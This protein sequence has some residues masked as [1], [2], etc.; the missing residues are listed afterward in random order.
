METTTAF[1]LN[2]A[3]QQWRENLRRLPA[4]RCGNLDELESHLRDSIATLQATGLSPEEALLIAARRL[5]SD[6]ALAIEFGKFNTR[7]VWFSRV[8]WALIGI[9]LW[10]FAGVFASTLASGAVFSGLSG[11]SYNF[12]KNGVLLPIILLTLANLVGFAG[13]LGLCWW[14]I[15]R[16]RKILHRRLSGA[17]KS[18]GTLALTFIAA[19]VLVCLVAVLVGVT[20]YLP[21]YYT[22]PKAFGMYT[23]C[24]AYSSSLMTVIKTTALVVITLYLARK[25]LC[26]GKA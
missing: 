10:Y 26:L 23:L 14:L 2:Q 12:D 17:L 20:R 3:I 15:R 13:V 8:L 24:G 19:I 18:H 25:Q 16:Y 6:N 22:D 9:Q 11:G 4:F 7:I 21:F 5:G 1:D